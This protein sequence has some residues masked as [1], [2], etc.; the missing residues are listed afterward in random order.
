MTEFAHLPKLEPEAVEALRAL[1]TEFNPRF[2]TSMRR[3]VGANVAEN[4]SV[5]KDTRWFKWTADQRKRFK[6][7]FA[8]R[9]SVTKALVGYFLE[10]PKNDGFL[11][12]MNTWVDAGDRAAI[13]VAYAL[14]DGQNITINDE[15]H[16]L[17]AGD[18]IAFRVSCLH[19][20]KKS[21]LDALWANTMVQGKLSDFT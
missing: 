8:N 21:K 12:L 19:E 10:F 15:K 9:P 18:G 17:N 20:V 13:I 3:R 2:A 16:I 1:Y 6:D 11:D 4:L 14:K 7:A 5:Y